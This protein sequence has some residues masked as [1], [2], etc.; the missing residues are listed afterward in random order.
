MDWFIDQIPVDTQIAIIWALFGTI[1]LIAVAITFCFTLCVFKL[2]KILCDGIKLED[3]RDYY[4][5]FGDTSNS[6]KS[7]IHR[8]SGKPGRPGKTPIPPVPERPQ[9][10]KNSLNPKGDENDRK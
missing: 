5:T 10:V 9:N 1:S 6:E 4:K 2:T 7:V 8:E 3:A